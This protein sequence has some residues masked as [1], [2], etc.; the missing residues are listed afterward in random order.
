MPAVVNPSRAHAYAHAHAREG[1]V[2]IFLIFLIALQ[3]YQ[4]YQGA[5]EKH[6]RGLI[7]LRPALSLAGQS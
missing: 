4:E 2:L 7:P 1:R 3:E 5:Q 6:P